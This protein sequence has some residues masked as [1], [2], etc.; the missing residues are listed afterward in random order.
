MSSWV[1]VC[2]IHEDPSPLIGSAVQWKQRKVQQGTLSMDRPCEID[3]CWPLYPRG[4]IIA[5]QWHHPVV[6][7][8]LVWLIYSVRLHVRVHQDVW[9]RYRSGVWDGFCMWVHVTTHTIL[10]G[11]CMCAHVSLPVIQFP[12]CSW[13]PHYS[14]FSLLFP[15]IHHFQ[16]VG[17]V[18][19][20]V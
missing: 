8:L 6:Q 18:V 4:W 16:S 13:A 9:I 15:I 1:G 17:C 11:V 19:G 3:L 12:S 20:A 2:I 14:F 7:R 5:V 10:L